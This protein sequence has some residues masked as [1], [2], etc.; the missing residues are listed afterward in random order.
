MN[1][2]TGSIDMR[3]NLSRFIKKLSTRNPTEIDT[4]ESFIASSRICKESITTIELS[5]T[6][7][8][9]VVG[10]SLPSEKALDFIRCEIGGSSMVKCLESTR[11]SLVLEVCRTGSKGEKAL[12][13]A[14]KVSIRVKRIPYQSK[15]LGYPL[16]SGS[17]C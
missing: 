10:G 17:S 15:V 4:L 13:N 7:Q 2:Y 14:N 16:Q 9:V 11:Y 5:I 6:N 12:Y 8:L 3:N 1:S